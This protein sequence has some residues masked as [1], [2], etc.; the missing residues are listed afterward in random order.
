VNLEA[1]PGGAP[2]LAAA[3][4]T[5]TRIAHPVDVV[6]LAAGQ[7][8]RMHSPCPKVL[9]RL[10]GK[11][12]IAHVLESVA[13]LAE[14]DP[15]LP[16]FTQ[17]SPRLNAVHL[18]LGFAA[19]QVR[20]AIEA[21][22][23]PKQ[24]GALRFH[25][26]QEQRGTGHAL[27]QAV[28]ALPSRG[29]TLVLFG[30]V[31]LIRASTL[32][33]LIAELGSEDATV[34]LTAERDKPYGYGRIVRDPHGELE[35]IVEERDATS[36]EKAIREVS[37]GIMLLPN[38]HLERWLNALSSDNAQAEYYLSDVVGF[39]HRDQLPLR[40]CCIDDSDQIEGVNTLAQ[41][42]ALE[43]IF[44]RRLADELLNQGV[45]VMDPARIDVRG[46]LRCG[47][48]VRIDVNCVF[49]GEVE[50]GDGVSVGAHCVLIDS[51]IGEGTELLAFTHCEGARVGPGSR[52]GPYARLRPGTELGSANQVGNFVEIKATR[53]G[54]H[55]KANHLTYLGDAVIG[56]RVNVGAGTI[57]CN[58]DGANKHLTV[59]EDDAFIGSDTQLVAP[60]RVGT[61]ATLGA[62]TTLT[63]DAPAG[64]LTVSR[65]SQQSLAGWKRPRKPEAS[66]D[67]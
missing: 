18:V 45:C 12:L 20:Q 56:S 48:G 49:E 19:E 17:A 51:V 62:G 24:L 60:V 2:A 7:G 34:V 21:S 57:T 3:H 28:H 29:H 40:A 22:D 55:S 36:D 58:Y 42:I 46:R 37:S 16:R 35:R 31:P 59:I 13:E 64:Q 25:L 63:R 41:L 33:L 23:L 47:R 8:K 61:G 53:T 10:G 66:T 27:R 52:V 26:Q 44:Q 54:A 15:Q 38:R 9:H 32:K 6:I 65:A 39:A 50:L 14:S 4:G 1:D 11:V 67:P 43:R 5:E 30:D